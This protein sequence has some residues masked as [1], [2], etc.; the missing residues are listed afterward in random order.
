MSK[1]KTLLLSIVIIS[2]PIA[3]ENISPELQQ[4]VPEF[5]TLTLKMEEKLETSAPEYR[6][7][8]LKIIESNTK[9][10]EGLNLEAIVNEV[11][12]EEEQKMLLKLKEL[13]NQ[14]KKLLKIAEMKEEYE[15]GGR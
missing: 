6:G 14:E 11:N 4:L 9:I 1:L 8:Y 2:A 3:A 5:E 15:N 7:G 13:I 10:V 12:E